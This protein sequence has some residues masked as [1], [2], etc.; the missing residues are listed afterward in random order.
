MACAYRHKLAVPNRK[1]DGLVFKPCFF[2]GLRSPGMPVYGIV[3]MLNEIGRRLFDQSIGYLLL[4][5]H[6]TTSFDTF[7]ILLSYS[8]RMLCA[9]CLPGFSKA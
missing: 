9:L 5:A 1:K 3:G 8:F 7:F 2:K 4:I 6:E